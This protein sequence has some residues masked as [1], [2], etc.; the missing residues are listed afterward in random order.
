[1]RHVTQWTP[2]VEKSIESF[3]VISKSI[4]VSEFGRETRL[5]HLSLAAYGV[6]ETNTICTLLPSPLCPRLAGLFHKYTFKHVHSCCL[7]KLPTKVRVGWH[8]NS[9]HIFKGIYNAIFRW[10]CDGIS[11]MKCI[12]RG[13]Y[14][15]SPCKTILMGLGVFLD[16]FTVFMIHKLR[17]LYVPLLGMPRDKIIR[18]NS[19]ESLNN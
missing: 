16:N 10:L 6:V 12:R 19:T 18:N 9:L 2:C 7:D 5:A 15:E 1:M 4:I 3:V 8:M 11:A 17:E 13:C 14:V